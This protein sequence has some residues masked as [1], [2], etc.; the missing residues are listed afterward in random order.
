MGVV[1]GLLEEGFELCEGL[2]ELFEEGA[3]A[4][5]HVRFSTAFSSKEL[6]HGRG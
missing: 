6:S 3:A 5:G 1:E 2:I 4:L